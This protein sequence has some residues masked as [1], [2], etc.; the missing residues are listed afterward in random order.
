MTTRGDSLTAGCVDLQH[1]IISQSTPTT[2]SISVL[3]LNKHRTKTE[4]FLL[5][6]HCMLF[7]WTL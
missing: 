7:D 6:L 3:S 1:I 2:C 5:L 4:I